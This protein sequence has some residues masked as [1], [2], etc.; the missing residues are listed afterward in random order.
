MDFFK[1]E[2]LES[3]IAFDP[4]DE[5]RTFGFEIDEWIN[6]RFTGSNPQNFLKRLSVKFVIK[7]FL[8]NEKKIGDERQIELAITKWRLGKSPADVAI[9]FLLS[10]V[11][12][13]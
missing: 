10:K 8:V 2:A 11:R 1:T 6:P 12:Q 4:F 7:L 3:R 9:L 13:K 5:S